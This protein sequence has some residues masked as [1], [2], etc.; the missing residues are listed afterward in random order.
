MNGSMMG[1]WGWSMMFWGVFGSALVVLAAAVVVWQLMGGNQRPSS[2][3][4]TPEEIIRRRLALGQISLEE[5]ERLES[6]LSS[7][8]QS[9]MPTA[10]HGESAR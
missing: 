5:Y 4:E 1:D 6:R 8:A 2:N 7:G 3:L 9:H 10:V